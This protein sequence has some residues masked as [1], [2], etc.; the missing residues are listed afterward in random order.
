MPLSLDGGG[1][2]TETARLLHVSRATGHLW[3]RR[4]RAEGLAGL[5]DARGGATCRRQVPEKP[6][7]SR[8]Y[9]RLPRSNGPVDLARWGCEID[10]HIAAAYN[11]PLR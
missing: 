1:S 4:F 8:P 11:V 10:E 9:S 3:Q 6:P 7:R 5:V 2:T